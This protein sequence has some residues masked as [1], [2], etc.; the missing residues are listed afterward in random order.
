MIEYFNFIFVGANILSL[1]AGVVIGMIIGALPGL[2]ATMVVSICLPLTF[3]L[4]PEQGLCLLLGIYNAAMFGGAIS[5]ILINIPGTPAAIATTFD[6]FPLCRQ[7]HSGLALTLSA[8]GS[9]GG[10]LISILALA[11]LAKPL[12]HLAL[13]FGPREF[14]ALAIFGL[15][16]MVSLSEESLVKSLVSGVFGLLLATIGIDSIHGVF[17]FTGGISR[18]AD[19]IPFIAVMIGMFGLTEVLLKMLARAEIFLQN[20]AEEKTRLFPTWNEIK[21]CTPAF[22]LSSLIGIVVGVIPGT[23]GDLA[24]LVAWEQSRRISRN[25]DA[26]GKGSIEGLVAAETAN[27]SV[28]GG[29]MSTMLFLGIPGDAVTAVLI[30]SL[31]MWGIQPGPLMYAQQPHLVHQIIGIMILATIL[32]MT[33][34]LWRTRTVAQWILKIPE[35]ILLPFIITLCVVGSYAVNYSW[36]DVV[37]MI[38]FGF[39]GVFLRSHGFPAAPLVLGLLLGP[40]AESNLRRA[41]I[42]AQEDEFYLLKS[43][44]ALFFYFMIALAMI[45]RIKSKIRTTP[46]WR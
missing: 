39:F 44:V 29:A 23:G 5:A 41:L 46:F 2:S 33:V 7:G 3:F 37:V 4:P 22:F 14:F 13:Q 45:N 35:Y 8:L 11:L 16:M 36:M 15:M 17:R 25:P 43:P 40:M 9:A 1:I 31:M 30:G 42:I 18:F 32:S 27:N 6:G 26:F 24:G 21:Q 28:I 34:C 10:G 38:L 19:G 20:Y 12:S